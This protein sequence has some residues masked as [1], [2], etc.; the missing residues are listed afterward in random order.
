MVISKQLLFL[1]GAT[2][3]HLIFMQKLTEGL[4]PRKKAQVEH[5]I[6]CATDFVLRIL[7]TFVVHYE[8]ISIRPYIRVWSFKVK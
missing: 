1:Q 2:F 8:E 5:T 6:Q 7:F 4:S 3:C